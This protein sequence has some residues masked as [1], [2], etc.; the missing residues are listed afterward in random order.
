MS[1]QPKARTDSGGVKYANPPSTS[2][3]GSF[4]K[5]PAVVRITDRSACTSATRNGARS[6]VAGP[7]AS[8]VRLRWF[9]IGAAFTQFANI[10][11]ALW[12]RAGAAP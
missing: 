12:V 2:H 5:G 6:P 4:A 10:A 1:V 11:L 8:D 9:L 7:S 3:V